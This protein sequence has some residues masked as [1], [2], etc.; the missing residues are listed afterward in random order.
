MGPSPSQERVLFCLAKHKPPKPVV[1][2][3]KPVGPVFIIYLSSLDLFSGCIIELNST[4]SKLNA[5]D[6][7]LGCRRNL[8][9]DVIFYSSNPYMSTQR[10]Y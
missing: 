10:C 2:G 6:M 7:C 9:F 3:S 8:N 4:L 1:T 5:Q